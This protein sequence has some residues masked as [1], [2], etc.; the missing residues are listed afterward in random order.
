M[1]ENKQLDMAANLIRKVQ[2]NLVDRIDSLKKNI[3]ALTAGGITVPAKP[4]KDLI[5]ALERLRAALNS[6]ILTLEKTIAGKSGATRG[7]KGTARKRK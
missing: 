5:R 6:A 2:E 4:R 7:K 1:P 3:R